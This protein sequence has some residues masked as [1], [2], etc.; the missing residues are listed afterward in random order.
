MYPLKE[1]GTQLVN[2]EGGL[3]AAFPVKGGSSPTSEYEILRGDLS[4]LLYDSSKD[5]EGVEYRFNSTIEAVLSNDEKAV[6][7]KFSDGSED[8]FDVLVAGEDPR[9][10]R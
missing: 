3:V 2:E 10:Q 8:S 5:L 4:K 7:V 9:A 1:E 6:T